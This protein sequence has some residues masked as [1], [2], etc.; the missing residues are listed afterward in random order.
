MHCVV[1]L[2]LFFSPVLHRHFSGTHLANNP[3]CMYVSGSSN[4]VSTITSSCPAL[5]SLLALEFGLVEDGE[6]IETHDQRCVCIP[7]N[8]K[9]THLSPIPTRSLI[10]LSF[11]LLLLLFLFLILSIFTTS[12]NLNQSF[13]RPF[14]CCSSRYSNFICEQESQWALSSPRAVS[15]IP[16]LVSRSGLVWSGLSLTYIASVPPSERKEGHTTLSTLPV[17]Y[18]VPCLTSLIFQQNTDTS[19]GCVPTPARLPTY[20]VK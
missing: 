8:P 14:S 19:Y 6:L 10:S 13:L 4:G 12:R 5:L 20:L 7:I 1:F 16:P 2:L 3:T 15:R 18:L 17:Y 9:R 11:F